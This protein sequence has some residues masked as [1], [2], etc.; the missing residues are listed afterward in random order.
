MRRTSGTSRRP[1]RIPRS[2][3]EG[4][5]IVKLQCPAGQANPVAAGG[6]GARSARRQHHGVLQGVQR[7]HA[8][9]GRADHPGHHHVY[10]DRSFTFELK[11][12]PAAVLLK[13][14]RQDRQGLGR[15]QPGEGRQGDAEQLR[16]DRRDQEG[17]P[18]RA[19]RRDGR[20][21]SSPARPARW[22]SRWR[23]RHAEALASATSE[24]SE[25]VDARASYYPAGG[26]RAPEG[27]ARPKFDES[28]DIAINLGVDPKHA[29]QMVRGAIVLP[30][31]TGSR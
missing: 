11:T 31:G 8:G 22:A 28:V 6:P 24:A 3:K 21:G 7:A 4:L 12:P 10:A 2:G 29:D 9:Q 25:A 15:A 23:A 19:R 13:K 27:A 5:A 17:R 20:C 18:E 14:R 30:H 26:G 1:R 16:G